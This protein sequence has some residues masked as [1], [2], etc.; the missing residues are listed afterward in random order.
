MLTLATNSR[1]FFWIFAAGTFAD[2]ENIGAFNSQIRLPRV[3]EDALA[4]V[5][6]YCI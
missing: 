2:R 1:A 6:A 4:A 3:P 5:E